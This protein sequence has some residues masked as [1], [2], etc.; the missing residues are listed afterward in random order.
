MKRVEILHKQIIELT[1]GMFEYERLNLTLS[2]NRLELKM[3][4]GQVYRGSF[5]IQGTKNQKIKGIIY[6]SNP[7]MTCLSTQFEGDSIEILYE[8]DAKGLSV[9]DSQVGRIYIVSNGGEYM[10]PFSVQMEPAFEHSS[11][12]EVKNLFHFAN[13]AHTN[14][15]E[16]FRM[17]TSKKFAYIFEKNER[18]YKTVYES[19]ASGF[20]SEQN[21]EEFLIAVNK[22]SKVEFQVENKDSSLEI[23]FQDLKENVLEKIV[24]TKSNWGYLCLEVR[25]D[26]PFILIGKNRIETNDFV[27][28]SC[29]FEYII[30]VEKL[31]AGKNFGSI[32]FNSPYQSVSCTVC[33]ENAIEAGTLGLIKEE[34]SNL[35]RLLDRYIKFRMKN[36]SSGMWAKD[37]LTSLERLQSLAGENT[38][39][40]LLQVQARLINQQ[41]EDAKWLLEHYEIQKQKEEKDPELYGYYLYLTTLCNPKKENIDNV[42]VQV[43]ELYQSNRKSWRLLWV[44]LFLDEGLEKNKTKKLQVIEEQIIS[45]CISPVLYLEAYYLILQDSFLL[46]HLGK[47]QLQLLSW[48]IKQ[49]AL[50]QGMASQLFQLASREKK[51]NPLLYKILDSACEKYITKENL[52]ILCGY[53]I[54]ADKQHSKYFKWYAKAVDYDLRI[55]RLYEYYMMALGNNREITIPQI[56]LLYFRYHSHLNYRTMAYL[57]TY[58]LEH[59]DENVEIF[60]SYRPLVERFVIDQ[61]LEKHFDENL[62]NLYRNILTPNML[63]PE[64]AESLSYL[65]FMHKITYHNK[66][67]SQVVV[68]HPQVDKEQVVPL[69]DGKSYVSIF[70]DDCQIVFQD[71]K[72]RRYGKEIK[73]KIKSLMPKES[74]YQECLRLF[75]FSVELAL[76]Y[77]EK[78]KTFKVEEEQNIK[79]LLNI[80]KSMKLK[81]SFKREIRT[82]IIY[83][84]YHNNQK[85]SNEIH[86]FFL[87]LNYRKLAVEERAKVI[88]LLILQGYYEGAYPI[89]CQYGWDRISV[90]A[91][92][93]LCTNYILREE[94]QT[95]EV[96]EDRFL[97]RLIYV[98][99]LEGKYNESLLKYLITYFNGTLHQMIK[100]WELAEQF[101]METFELS[102]RILVQTLFTGEYLSKVDK[103]FS[104]YYQKGA[105]RKVKDAYFSYHCYQ[106]FVR[107]RV[108]TDKFIKCLKREY[109]RKEEL[110]EISKLTLFKVLSERELDEEAE[111]IVR[112]LMEEYIAK[113]MHF[114]FYQ[115]FPVNIT[116]FYQINDKQYIEYIG[117]QKNRIELHY[118][119]N[120]ESK[121]KSDFIVEEM[122]HMFEGIFVKPITMFFG[123][124][125][126]YY[127]TQIQDKDE[128][129]TECISISKSDLPAEQR[130]NRYDLLNDIILCY[131]LRDNRA[132][133]A[134]MEQFIEKVFISKR[135]FKIK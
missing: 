116:S 51:F 72:G 41:T 32:T 71:K 104:V 33:V 85:Y 15:E 31:H 17:F 92:L 124:N 28:K 19:F 101:E 79:I 125:L 123:E 16:A 80:E 84:Y 122:P 95:G 43:R 89:V 1:N 60:R 115:N 50:T 23:E 58:I 105:R 40:L 73:Y 25:T 45:G 128:K 37:T 62:A 11:I 42:T 131:T 133:E 114:K 44:L 132:M 13:L 6:S 99:V 54:K 20:V 82:E 22:K 56:V 63:T 98:C 96:Q 64:L 130:E 34:K 7:R 113:D 3:Q 88:E 103:I 111:E 93:R 102:E 59:K 4:I 21:M 119:L 47:A 97:T 52:S 83:Y 2:A 53:L 27:G 94:E 108:L 109:L 117:N 91:L 66:H 14:W 18:Q 87:Q 48:I 134:L 5:H 75:P 26:A 24:I 55:T 68:T 112:E 76:F 120:A 126:Q 39:Y 100:V 65:L 46:N 127:L 8:F 67:M 9:G 30:D 35:R 49:E 61:I 110:R 36:I 38:W 118:K 90:R 70:S 129:I 81:E 106:Y 69:I 12:G 135:V 121:Q 107:Q 29:A 74:L 57:Y 77:M 86:E 10:I 78:K